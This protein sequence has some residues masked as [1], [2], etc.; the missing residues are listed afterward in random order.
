[1]FHW[2][3][4]PSENLLVFSRIRC[5]FMEY[6]AFLLVQLSL[7][8]LELMSYMELGERTDRKSFKV[9]FRLDLVFFVFRTLRIS[10]Q[11]SSL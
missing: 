9:K 11:L 3:F 6:R 10:F 4:G 8:H 5:R 1:M 2:K 7:L